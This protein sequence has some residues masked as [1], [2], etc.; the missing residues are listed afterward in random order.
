MMARESWRHIV[1][2]SPLDEHGQDLA[3]YG[4]LIGLIALVVIGAVM[5]LGNG[6]NLLL[7][8]IATEVGP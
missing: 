5:L 2:Q 6:F 7:G 3:E 1:G 8:A 4:L